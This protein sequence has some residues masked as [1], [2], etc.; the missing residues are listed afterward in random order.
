MEKFLVGSVFA[1]ALLAS[2]VAVFEPAAVAVALV[3]AVGA[4]FVAMAKKRIGRRVTAETVKPR[5]ITELA[6]FPLVV[7]VRQSPTVT[8]VLLGALLLVALC[9]KVDPERG[10]LY[11]LPFTLL[12]LS[13]LVV[14]RSDLGIN[15]V[16]VGL[17]AAVVLVLA[18][19]VPRA[20][21]L[22]SLGLGLVVYL[23]GNVAGQLAHIPS[24]LDASRLGGYETSAGFFATRLVFP[25]ARS[26]NEPAVIAAAYFGL[27]AAIWVTGRR[28]GWFHVLGLAAAAY[29]L[30]GSNSRLPLVIAVLLSLAALL[31][32]LFAMRVSRPMVFV[33]GALPFYLPLAEP[34][35]RAVAGAVAGNALLSR[36]QSVE[37]IVG[38]GTRGTIWSG[39]VDFWNSAM[40]MDLGRRL[41]GFG[42]NG[43]AVS[44]ANTTYLHGLGGFLANKDNLTMHN[45]FLQ[46]LFDGGLVGLALL[47]VGLLMV[48]RRFSKDASLLPQLVFAT[49][50]GVGA[51]SEIILAPGFTQTPFFLL[52]AFAAFSA[53]TGREPHTPESSYSL[54]NR[55]Q[56]TTAGQSAR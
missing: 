31:S 21:A 23:I 37:D 53:T 8:V 17:A 29:I 18:T 22:Y 15:A 48:L 12:A 1:A 6:L 35:I 3:L 5:L 11:L 50:L 30:V 44:G 14:F 7:S 55:Q 20:A 39:S 41:F 49:V 56:L 51:A 46:M 54:P 38:L 45:S 33:A 10:R 32:P 16:I 28:V 36:G 4:A 9:R 47:A 2:V 40:V 27:V 34:V 19:K 13:A 52:L 42:L 25:F 26:I 43:H 24:P